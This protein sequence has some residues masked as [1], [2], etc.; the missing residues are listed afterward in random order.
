MMYQIFISTQSIFVIVDWF[1]DIFDVNIFFWRR[2]GQIVAAAILVNRRFWK[3]DNVATS[4][5]GT[6]NV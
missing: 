4:G 6:E 1:V 3:T 5:Q 2:F